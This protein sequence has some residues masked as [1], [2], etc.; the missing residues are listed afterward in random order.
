MAAFGEGVRL[1]ERDTFRNHKGNQIFTIHESFGTDFLQGIGKIDTV[2]AFASGEH[3]GRDGFYTGVEGD[4]FQHRT[5]TE[6]MGSQGFQRRRKGDFFQGAAAFKGRFADFDQGF[7]QPQGLETAAAGEGAGRNKTYGIRKADG[8][9]GSA[10]IENRILNGCQGFGETNLL[11][12]G[13][14]MESIGRDPGDRIR[15]VDGFQVFAAVEG[16]LF[17]DMDRIRE[18]DR[19]QMNPVGKSLLIND[20]NGVR[21]DV[22]MV[23]LFKGIE[24]KTL[25]LSVDEHVVIGHENRMIRRHGDGRKGDTA[26]EGAA[27]YFLEVGG[28]VDGGERITGSESV[29]PELG[30]IFRQGDEPEAAAFRKGFRTNQVQRIRQ[31]DR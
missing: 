21:H 5:G 23:M 12:T 3:H 19:F 1:E 9:E 15:N 6:D 13:T 31:I 26:G 27:A 20:G 29:F 2:Q 8:G 14:S 10:G 24:D 11:K 22:V 28:D 7:R 30:Q 25:I 18:G 4:R 17:D 16:F